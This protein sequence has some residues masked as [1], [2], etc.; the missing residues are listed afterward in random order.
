MFAELTLTSMVLT[1]FVLIALFIIVKNFRMPENFYENQKLRS[2]IRKNIIISNM[3]D[4][5]SDEKSGKP[6]T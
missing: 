2:N 5:G 3:E 6:Q 4:E 1:I